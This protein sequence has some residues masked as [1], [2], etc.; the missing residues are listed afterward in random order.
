MN[1]LDQQQLRQHVTIVALLQILPSVLI[2]LLAGFAFLFLAGIG[3]F[4]GESGVFGILL[5]VGAAAGA[6][7]GVLALPGI[8]AG[9]G[10][11]LRKEWGRFLALL[12]GVLG[13]VNIPVGTLIGI[14]TVW[15]LMQDEAGPYFGGTGSGTALAS[16]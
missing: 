8:F 2:L 7:L 10:L 1:Q 14:Y 9:M 11:L 15:V 13:L 5:V 6:F 3:A 12:V 16:V 4:V